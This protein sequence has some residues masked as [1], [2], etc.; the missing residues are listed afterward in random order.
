MRLLLKRLRS[1]W[2]RDMPCEHAVSVRLKCIETDHQLY[3]TSKVPSN[4]VHQCRKCKKIY[5][6]FVLR[7]E[8]MRNYK[9]VEDLL[10]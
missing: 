9:I 7:M 8:I 5:T 3:F 6:E 1:E 4:T 2:N 10:K